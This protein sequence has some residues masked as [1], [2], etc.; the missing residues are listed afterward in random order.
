MWSPTFLDTNGA[1]LIFCGSD[2]LGHV[3]ATEIV[4]SA[5]VKN[6]DEPS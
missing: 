2:S 3:R 4:V 6:F 1:D 5:Y